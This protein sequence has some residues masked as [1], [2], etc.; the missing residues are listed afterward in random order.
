MIGVQN[1]RRSYV[2][3]HGNSLLMAAIDYRY[4]DLIPMIISKR[5]SLLNTVD[6]LKNTASSKANMI[7]VVSLLLETGEVDSNSHNNDRRTCCQ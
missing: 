4:L 6:L 1:T 7:D 5:L 3:C 2:N